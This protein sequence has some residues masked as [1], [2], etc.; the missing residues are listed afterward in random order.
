M[1]IL[2]TAKDRKSIIKL[3]SKSAEFLIK[4][5]SHNISTEMLKEKEIRMRER[6]NISSIKDKIE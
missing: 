5:N 1:G 6:F 3:V 4:Q 2:T